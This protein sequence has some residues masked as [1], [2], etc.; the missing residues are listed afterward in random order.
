M[1]KQRQRARYLLA[2][3]ANRK[4]K[5][6]DREAKHEQQTGNNPKS[7]QETSSRRQKMQSYLPRAIVI[8][9]FIFRT[10]KGFFH[11]VT[12]L[13]NLSIAWKQLHV[14]T[15]GQTQTRSSASK[16]RVLSLLQ[17]TNINMEDNQQNSIKNPIDAHY[18]FLIHGWLGNPNEMGFLES[19]INRFAESASIANANANANTNTNTNVKAARIVTHSA[20][21]NDAKTTDGIAIGGIRLAQEIQQFIIDDIQSNMDGSATNSNK[22]PEPEH[23]CTISFVGNSL[24]G[25]YARYA[26]SRLPDKLPLQSDSGQETTPCVHLQRQIFVTTAT[27]H[28]G[29]ASNTFLP[30]PRTLEQGISRILNLTGRDLFRTDDIDVIY[31]MSTDYD[32]FLKPLSLFHKRIAFANAFRTDFQVP[33]STAAFLSK[34]STYPHFIEKDV[35]HPFIV[36]VAR[37]EENLEVLKG[38]IDERIP[39]K[40][41]AMSVKLDSLG[42]QKVFVD[43]RDYIPLPGIALPS[44][45][46]TGSRQ[47]WNDFISGGGERKKQVESRDLLRSLSGSDR[48]DIPVGHQ[49]MVANSKNQSYSRFTAK[50]RPVMDYLANWMVTDLTQE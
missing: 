44:F 42:W 47:K 43:V 31:Q 27:P 1:S 5:R 28:L 13:Q 16:T 6:E 17:R 37:T 10:S 50:G 8:L 11:P 40:R 12:P 29:V 22:V 21:C 35:D 24:G 34:E 23:H 20:I 41:H 30:L 3:T 9:S 25:L 38:K 14:G 36:A 48:F 2:R 49:I 46:T 45:L 18:I 15:I 39:C 26:L 4:T 33:T 7:N 32:T 19:S